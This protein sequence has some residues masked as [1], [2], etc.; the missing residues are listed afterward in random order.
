MQLYSLSMWSRMPRSL[1]L[2]G[3]LLA[4]CGSPPRLAS[5]SRA[6]STAQDVLIRDVS[7]FDGVDMVPRRDV[8]ITGARIGAVAPA[9]ALDAPSGAL[10]LAGV[11]R[12][13]LPGLIDSHAHL[14]SAG[15]KTGP[16]PDPGAIAEAFLFAGATSVLVAAD[17]GNT[18]NLTRR[19]VEEGVLAPHLFTAGAGLTAPG[20]HPIPLLRA[21]LPWPVDWLATRRI[22]TAAGAA[23]ARAQVRSILAESS[24]DFLKIVYDDLPPGR[25]PHLSLESLRAAISE[26]RS[27]GV[28]PLV[29]ATTPRDVMDAIDAGAA[30]LAHLPQRG[31]LTD[32]QVMRLVASD[33]PIVTTVRLVSASHQLAARG[34]IPLEREMYGPELLQPWLDDPGWNLV[35]FS[36]EIDS[37]PDDVA[38]VTAANFRKLLAADVRMFVGTDSG[39]HGVFPGA[40]LHREMRLLVE[41]GMSPEKVLRAATSAPAAFLD[42]A[43]TFGRIAPGQRADLLLVRGDPTTDIGALAAIEEVFLDGIRLQR[44]AFEPPTPEAPTGGGA[45]R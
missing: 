27:H 30:L 29:H 19:G 1:V 5:V 2:L 37:R 22:P 41:L 14:F 18:E 20:G 31:I 4:A 6:V 12:T 8:L 17:V 16:P 15:E 28:R 42:P 45:T 26:A 43:G 13:L 7:V 24:P 11:G 33:V 36:E 34:A 40:S 10:E 23:E 3:L 44:H 32:E 21:L 25:S 39:V 9:G 35:G 38:A